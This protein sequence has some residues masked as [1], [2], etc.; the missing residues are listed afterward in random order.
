[1]K[2]QNKDLKSN[3]DLKGKTKG[4]W[5]YL[6]HIES[7][8]LIGFFELI[9]VFLSVTPSFPIK[10]MKFIFHTFPIHAA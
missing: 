9:Y 6:T 1:M 10:L 5:G 7:V 3:H 4:D 2:S 8:F